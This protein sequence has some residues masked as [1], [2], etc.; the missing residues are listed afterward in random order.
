MSYHVIYT[1][2]TVYAIRSVWVWYPVVIFE[3]Q[4]DLVRGACGLFSRESS[5]DQLVRVRD[6]IGML[7]SDGKS[8]TF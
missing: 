3:G 6:V 4:D 1:I 2:Y 5:N 8:L 7:N